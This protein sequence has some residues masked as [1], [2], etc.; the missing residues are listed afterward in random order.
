MLK[1]S[2]YKAIC[3]AGHRWTPRAYI[4]NLEMSY[5][6][7]E[8]FS[9]QH[10]TCAVDVGANEGQYRNFLRRRCGYEVL[11]ISFEPV[12]EVFNIIQ[13]RAKSDSNWLVF[14]CAL[15]ARSGKLEINVMQDS[16]FS[17]FLSPN[18]AEI[19]RPDIKTKNVI[20]RRQEVQVRTVPE[21]LADVGSEHDLS[22]VYLKMDTQGYDFEVLRGAGTALDRVVALQTEVP[23]KPLYEGMVTFSGAIAELAH[24]GYEVTGLYPVTRD[25]LLRVIEFDCVAVKVAEGG[26]PVAVGLPGA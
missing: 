5:H 21:A 2:A 17:S 25:R 19:D 18:L 1:D 16:H 11:I 15:G 20:A 12:R 13:Q 8:L 9:T 24:Y 22:R 7:R 10:V 6:L 14:N 3:A 4:N 26:R 23:V